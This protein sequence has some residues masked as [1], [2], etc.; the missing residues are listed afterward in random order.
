MHVIFQ[1]PCIEDKDVSCEVQ[2]SSLCPE[3][4]VNLQNI[5]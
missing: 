4:N 1:N 5:L 3:E 2:T